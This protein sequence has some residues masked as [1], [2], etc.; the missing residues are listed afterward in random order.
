VKTVFVAVDQIRVRQKS[1]NTEELL[2]VASNHNWCP[3]SRVHRARVSPAL[4]QKCDHSDF[5]F[6]SSDMKWS[7][8]M[9][10]S[11]LQVGSS[12]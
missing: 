7:G 11:E 12:L 10:S 1:L 5:A 8:L 4:H 9:L 2:M 6:M 3:Q